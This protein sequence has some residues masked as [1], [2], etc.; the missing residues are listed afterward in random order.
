MDV[1]KY[2]NLVFKFTKNNSMDQF[3]FKYSTSY[4]VHSY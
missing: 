3:S 1:L 4:A 2:P